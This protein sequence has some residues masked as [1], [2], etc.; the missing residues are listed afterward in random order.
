MFDASIHPATRPGDY[1]VVAALVPPDSAA[2]LS[3]AL[4]VAIEKVTVE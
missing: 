2:R 3:T 1:T 4:A